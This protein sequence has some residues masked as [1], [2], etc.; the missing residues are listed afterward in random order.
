[1]IK[2]GVYLSVGPHAGGSFQYCLSVIKNLNLI[3]KKKY[4]IIIFTNKNFWINRLNSKYKIIKL[5]SNN[6]LGQIINYFYFLLKPLKLFKTV[7]NLFCKNVR[8][9]NNSFFN[10]FFMPK[11]C[12]D[13][14]I[15]F[16]II[17]FQILLQIFFCPKNMLSWPD[18]HFFKNE[19]KNV[20]NSI[21]AF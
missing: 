11:R 17:V 6:F 5:D 4:K 19:K 7:N 10:L 18:S 1:M 8:K 12:E 15:L 20:S 14:Y 9:M 13:P 16:L 2:I 21:T 3:N